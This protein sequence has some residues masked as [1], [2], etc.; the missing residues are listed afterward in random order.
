[1]KKIVVLGDSFTYG[2]GCS[3]RVF[4]K[5]A[6]T[7][8]FV[9]S[10]DN[11]IKNSPSQY[12]WASL[13]QRDYTNLQVYNL[14]EPGN[15]NQSMFR[16]L[17]EFLQ[18]DSNFDI[19]MILFMGTLTDRMDIGDTKGNLQSWTLTSDLVGE[20][21][22]PTDGF[23]LAKKMYITWL[24]DYNIGNYLGLMSLLAC[25]NLATMANSKFYYNIHGHYASSKLFSN[26]IKLCKDKEIP[27]I[28]NFDFSE[29]RDTIFNGTCMSPDG[30]V[31]EKGHEIYYNRVIK[32]L[33]QKELL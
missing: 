3:D 16:N 30:H 1:M 29:S 20:L 6:H 33:V 15:S 24:Y 9:G 19:D 12:C 27:I 28:S 5:D 14:A 8:E 2:H 7:K 23:N 31:N 4:Y 22:E 18:D 32:P 26:I 10:R 13:L 11:L 21:M 17:C 25:Y